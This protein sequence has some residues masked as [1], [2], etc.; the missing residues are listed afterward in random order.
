LINAKRSLVYYSALQIAGA[1]AIPRAA[2]IVSHDARRFGIWAQENPAVE[3]FAIDLATYRYPGDWREQ[4][5][6]L[7]IFDSMTDRRI[8][9]L[10]NGATTQQRCEH[11]FEI[12]G[13]DRVRI[14]NA[15][16]QARTPQRR[17]RPTG[18]QTGVTFKRRL[19]VRRGVVERAALKSRQQQ[20][21][22][23]AA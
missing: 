3:L 1:Y 16:T 4:L 17:V 22:R 23:R 6:G 9:Y 20:L 15:T 8:T 19:A 12:A 11:L 18:D 2:W 13:P 7:Q 21:D 10:I 5:E 14:T